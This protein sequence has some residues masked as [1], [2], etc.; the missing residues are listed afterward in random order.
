MGHTHCSVS[1]RHRLPEHAAARRRDATHA[2]PQPPLTLRQISS[3]LDLP[4]RTLYNW[5]T[6]GRFLPVRRN[7]RGG[8]LYEVEHIRRAVE[9]SGLAR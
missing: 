9:K 6:E 1:G 3:L 5:E 8:K 4:L 7:S 2:L